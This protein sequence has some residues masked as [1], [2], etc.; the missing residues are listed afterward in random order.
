MAMTKEPR[1]GRSAGFNPDAGWEYVE[2]LVDRL[3]RRVAHL[4]VLLPAK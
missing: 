4:T 1:F 3:A 2:Q